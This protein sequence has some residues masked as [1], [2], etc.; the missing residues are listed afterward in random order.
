MSIRYAFEKVGMTSAFTEAGKAL[1]VSVLKLKPAKVVRHETLKDGRVV[2]VVEYDTGKRKKLTRGYVVENA[3]DYEVGSELA[4]PSLAV[5]SK[6]AVTGI[7]KGRGFQ[8]VVKRY[9]FAGGPAS[10]GSRFHR[11]PGS[12]GM[13]TEPGRTPKGHRM[14]GQMGNVKVTLRNLKVAYWSS[15]ESV[16]ALVGGVPGARGGIVFI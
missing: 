5:D 9:N 10:H 4:A 11:A 8:G 3:A 13:R 12:A 1:G 6:V 16:L 2:V 14:P 15:E 7:T